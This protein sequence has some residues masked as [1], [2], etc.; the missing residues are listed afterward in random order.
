MIGRDLIRLEGVAPQFEELSKP[1]GQLIK[2]L[3]EEGTKGA[4]RLRRG[5]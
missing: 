3:G 1:V 2:T 5:T 4:E